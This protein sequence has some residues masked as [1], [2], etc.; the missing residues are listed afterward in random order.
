MAG[1]SKSIGLVA[2][3]ASCSVSGG[4]DL[5]A[6]NASAV[7]EA[8]ASASAASTADAGTPDAT[9]TT[10]DWRDAARRFHWKLAHDLIGKLDSKKQQTARIR[11]ATGWIALQ[12][13]R[14]ADAVV[15]LEGLAEELPLARN[16][17]S[18]WYAEA[19]AH[20]G[21]F[22]RAGATLGGS[23]LVRDNI[24]GALAYQRGGDLGKARVVI[25]TA[26][27]RAQ[28]NKRKS[29]EAQAHLVRAGIAEAQKQK[30]VAAG[31]Y[32]WLVDNAR[33][34][35]MVRDA[36]EGVDRNA[37]ILPLDA[38]L[39]AIAKSTS[40]LNLEKTLVLLKALETKHPSQVAAHALTRARAIYHGRAYARARDAFDA[41]ARFPSPFV[42]EAEYYA[43]RAAAR[44]GDESSAI[45]RYRAAST[46]HASN[47]WGER[48][49]Y[50]HAELLLSTA[51][52]KKAARAF[53]SYT[54][55]FR[56]SRHRQDAHYGRAMALLSGSQPKKAA[57][58]FKAMRKKA[59]KRRTIASLQHLEGVAAQRAGKLARAKKLWLDLIAK[60]PL[61]WAALA[62]HARLKSVGHT[63]MPPLIG[64]PETVKHTALAIALP[65]APRLFQELGLDMVAERRLAG[66]EQEAA[67]AYP[68]R[69][70]EALC[71]MYG[72]LTTAR[73]RS[74]VG[75]RAVSLD[76]LM[77]PP[78]RAER[79]AW[80]CVYPQPYA[81]IVAREEKRFGLPVG[82]V[83]AIMRQESAF[84]TTAISSVGARGLMQLMPNTAVRAAKEIP[85]DLELEEVWHPNVN[86]KLGSFY[87]GKLMRNFK[88][89]VPLAAAGYNAG[90]Q[91][92]Q[93]WL[94][95]GGDRDLDI[96]VSRIPYRETR[97]YV[98]RVMTNISRYQ[99]LTGGKSAIMELRLPIP[100]DTK[101][102]D[103]A[104]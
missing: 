95:A 57:K 53:A 50:R 55:R 84:K 70:S 52:Y 48:S 26:I 12:A 79:W 3:V 94:G 96:W 24:L 51:Q 25:D 85:I 93:R 45:K 23:P 10:T 36:L 49:A 104:Y 88:G 69:E 13:G 46:R 99:Y 43:A 6:G 61:T 44:A 98:Q 89:S 68:S 41:V 33:D 15:A 34:D 31:D 22:D 72:Q 1:V 40:P 30:A 75:N 91:A 100:S 76:V 66:M 29:Q 59:K 38:R 97:M 74:R 77:R 11:L 2:L 64:G 19:A 103:D 92:V 39:A 101:I 102:D 32:R 62:A 47:A 16:E 87:L 80:H 71:E 56:D 42:A 17:I 83:H 78:S 54:S 82:M 20:A 18:D 21:P 67:R 28:R 86:L 63:P 9:T 58:L 37:G 27:R 60:Q 73:Q 81:A 5:P 7:A 14:H 90:P 4:V 65:G 8:A 35:K